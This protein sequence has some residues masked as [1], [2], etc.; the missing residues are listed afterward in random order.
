MV[1]EE[2][3]VQVAALVHSSVSNHTF[4]R[5]SMN[6]LGPAVQVTTY[7]TLSF[8]L[9][10]MPERSTMFSQGSC[11]LQLWDPTHHTPVVNPKMSLLRQRDSSSVHFSVRCIPAVG[12][13]R[14]VAVRIALLSVMKSLLEH[15]DAGR[16]GIGLKKSPADLTRSCDAR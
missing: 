1:Q 15:R 13:F 8:A 10:C 9:V 12:D 6:C 4:L 16:A 2:A 14:L 11:T 3:D 7:P 5:C